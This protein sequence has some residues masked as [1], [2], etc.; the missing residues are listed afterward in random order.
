[1]GCGGAVTAPPPVVQPTPPV[2]QPRADVADLS[3]AL[4]PLAWWLGDWE[5]DHGREHW[6]AANGAMFGV[7]FAI[8][9]SFEVMIVDDGEGPGKP[10][11]VLRFLAMPN[12]ASSVEFRKR[13]LTPKSVLF[14]NDAHDFPKNIRYGIEGD[15]LAAQIY[16][17]DASIKRIAYAFRR[18]KREPAPELEAADRA[19]ADDTAARGIDGWVAAFT[20][21]AGM[22]KKG[23]RVQ[24]HDAIKELM[25]PLLGAGK[26][27]W[28]PTAS[29]KQ[30]K[31]G[32]TV[33]KATFT[34]AKPADSWR[35]SYVTIWKQTSAGW[36]VLFDAGRVVNE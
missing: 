31:L 9:D 36:K 3:P 4:A 7:A 35:S 22:L 13:E 26:L 21:D 11:G 32:F 28:A 17:D 2:D 8:D 15:G 18:G 19:F 30:G 23:T 20:G 29:G 5:G 33:G 10:D 24:G 27:A 14:T 12:G 25:G 16:G 1:L 34:G 6:V